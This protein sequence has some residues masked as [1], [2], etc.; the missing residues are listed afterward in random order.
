[1]QLKT[2]SEAIRMDCL[3]AIQLFLREDC[4]TLIFSHFFKFLTNW[5]FHNSHLIVVFCH[6][7]HLLHFLK[8]LLLK[9]F[10]NCI[11]E[12]NEV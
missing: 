1:M 9:S 4:D 8:M 11:N 10:K 12:N 5:L 2:E 7:C 3:S 6:I